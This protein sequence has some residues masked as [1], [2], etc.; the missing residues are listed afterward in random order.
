MLHLYLFAAKFIFTKIVNHA[1][2]VEVADRFILGEDCFNNIMEHHNI[3]CFD[4]GFDSINRL[5]MELGC[6]IPFEDNLFKYHHRLKP[7]F[8]YI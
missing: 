6:I 7:F 1:D 4:S 2:W 8:I 3:D 5:L